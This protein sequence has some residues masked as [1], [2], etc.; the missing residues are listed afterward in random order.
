[1]HI[2][3]RMILSIKSSKL[4]AL[5]RV[6]VYWVAFMGLLYLCGTF[7]PGFFPATF[8]RFIY[9]LSGT[10]AAWILFLIFSRMET[11]TAI[12]FGLGLERGSFFRFLI[13]LLTG[14]FLFILILA[15][16]LAS[17]DLVLSV[18]PRT[19]AYE[20]FFGYLAIIPLAWMEE[21]AFRSYPF[22]KLSSLFGLRVTQVIVALV[23]AMYHMLGGQS[24]WGSLIGPGTWAFVFG[25]AAAWSH[26]IALP[27]GIHIALNVWQPLS[28]MN[29]GLPALFIL[30][31]STGDSESIQKL[32]EIVG[33]FIQIG[34]LA[35][36][37]LA[38]EL[39]LR[40]NKNSPKT[41]LT[42]NRPSNQITAKE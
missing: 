42:P 22:F 19:P 1:M 36:G 34:V 41:H 18:N 37:L 4:Q 29:G 20:A 13:G 2:S 24:M 6:L 23:F 14:T 30:K 39:F 17:T 5:F 10:L 25:I 31:Y 26:G 32:E 21:I 28:G 7:L 35:I 11:G 15:I 3:H 27:L 12:D 9:G 8:S 38:T 40:K 16:L 33:M